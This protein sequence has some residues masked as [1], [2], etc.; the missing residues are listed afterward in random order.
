HPQVGHLQVRVRSQGGGHDHR[1]RVVGVGRTA[2]VG[3]V[4]LVIGIS[5]D[6]D[7]DL[8]GAARPVRQGEGVLP[9]AGA[10]RLDGAVGGGVVGESRGG[11]G[12]AG[13][14]VLDGHVVGPR[15]GGGAVSGVGVVPV[16]DEVGAGLQA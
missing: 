1:G 7:L 9:G 5:G 15:A 2:G 8:A 10:A 4:D 14:G 12:L 11:E 13:G 16:D 6:I 3:L